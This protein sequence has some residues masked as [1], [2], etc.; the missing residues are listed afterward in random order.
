MGISGCLRLLAVDQLAAGRGL[1]LMQETARPC[2]IWR[3]EHFRQNSLL[4]RLQKSARRAFAERAGKI[5]ER[6]RCSGLTHTQRSAEQTR[7]KP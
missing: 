6:Q 2:Q 7:K 4:G 1:G 3:F 5:V